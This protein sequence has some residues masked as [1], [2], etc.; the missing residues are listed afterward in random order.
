MFEGWT[1]DWAIN[2]VSQW[3]SSG[4]P[5]IA[6]YNYAYNRDG[7]LFGL[8]GGEGKSRP[9]YNL[10]EDELWGG[11][12]QSLIDL[13]SN[14]VAGVLPLIIEEL[15]TRANEDIG[16]NIGS[17][18][19]LPDIMGGGP[20]SFGYNAPN[21]MSGG[22]PMYGTVNP[23]T[24]NVSEWGDTPPKPIDYTQKAPD[25]WTSNPT[26]TYGPSVD[27]GM[28]SVGQQINPDQ[29][30]QWLSGSQE[31]LFSSLPSGYGS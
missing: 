29:Y 16:Y 22:T 24:G 12:S 6:L 28:A 14:N 26:P 25:N 23:N 9:A 3:G 27:K 5:Q 2:P 19:G 7:N 20:G 11:S 30:K 31:P 17:Q 18:Y 8:G 4:L 21:T 10:T 13:A 1:T 15:R